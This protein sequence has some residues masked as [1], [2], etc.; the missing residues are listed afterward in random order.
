[1][2]TVK[3][4]AGGEVAEGGGG[5]ADQLDA[6][7]TGKGDGREQRLTEAGLKLAE[8]AWAPVTARVNLAVEK[9]GLPLSEDRDLPLGGAKAS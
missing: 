8:Q 7:L 2:A 9:F 4:L 1:M 6:Q 3:A 5:P